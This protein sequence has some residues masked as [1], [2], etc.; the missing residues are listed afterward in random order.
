[1]AKDVLMPA[2][3]PS[4]RAGRLTRWL[5]REGDF[6]EAGDPIAEIATES[7][8]MDVEAPHSGVLVR[9]LVE[10]G[11]AP[12]AVNRP[13]ALIDPRSAPHQRPRMDDAQ[14]HPGEKGRA[15]ASP[16]ARRL[17]HQAGCDLAVVA[18]SGPHGRIVE[19]DV[20]AALAERTSDHEQARVLAPI[21]ERV[22]SP[23]SLPGVKWAPQ[24]HLETDCNVE[25]L[26]KLRTRL[27]DSAR[28]EISAPIA[29]V[30]CVVKALALALH[31]TP[32][33]N[34]A[35]AANG[36]A[37]ARRC[38]IALAMALEGR[39]AAPTL[40]SAENLALAEIAASRAQ[41]MAGRHPAAAHPGGSSLVLDFGDFGVKR[42]FPVVVAPWTLVL[43]IGEA[44]NRD[45]VED[46][47]PAVAA[48]LSVTLTIDR[49]AM[50]EIAGAMLLDAFRRLIENPYGLLL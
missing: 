42:V 29:L 2:V 30:D 50:D 22:P 46:S 13:I 26:E 45:V 41:F 3:G 35:H 48:I 16:R 17:A 12:I 40:P 36:F 47:V 33:A 32:R 21:C 24:A 1:M 37:P 15:P 39:L 23:L 10:E 25:A 7:A 6:V 18:G 28:E 8:T 9:L 49:R 4:M 20:R 44:E 14:A 5:R 34:V 38:D 19:R 27:N 11:S 31:R 43:S